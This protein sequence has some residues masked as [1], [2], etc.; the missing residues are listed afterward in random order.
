MCLRE[1]LTGIERERTRRKKENCPPL[2]V[3]SILIEKRH[4]AA[5]H[6]QNHWWGLSRTSIEGARDRNSKRIESRKQR[7]RKQIG[8]KQMSKIRIHVVFQVVIPP[9][10]QA[11]SL[12]AAPLQWL[13]L[14]SMANVLPANWP[15]GARWRPGLCRSSGTGPSIWECLTPSILLSLGLSL[16]LHPSPLVA[17]TGTQMSCVDGSCTSHVAQHLSPGPEGPRPRP[18][19]W[20]PER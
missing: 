15:E 20:W 4:E 3:C 9:T 19:D 8:G 2:K 13:L 1:Y 10:E 7:S 16:S 14:E 18:P 6:S 5:T 11:D 17:C 12:S